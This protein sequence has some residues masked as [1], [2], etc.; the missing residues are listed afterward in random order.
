MAWHTWHDL[1]GHLDRPAAKLCDFGLARMRSELC[2]SLGNDESGVFLPVCSESSQVP[3]SVF[4]SATL[5]KPLPTTSFKLQAILAQDCLDL[6]G[7]S[8]HEIPGTGSMQ[9]A[10]TAPYMA[11]ASIQPMFATSLGRWDASTCLVHLVRLRKAPE[12]FAKRK[13]DETA[14]T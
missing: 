6:L 4:S 13:Y 14:T 7:I 8:W 11:T 5:D 2:F 9:W 12:L 10:G 3:K 1:L